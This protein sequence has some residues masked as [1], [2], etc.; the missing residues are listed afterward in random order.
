MEEKQK[1]DLLFETKS[2]EQKKKKHGKLLRTVIILILAAAAL[3]WG[4]ARLTRRVEKYVQES[5]D[6]VKTATVEYGAVNATVTGSGPIEDV[7]PEDISVPA[8]V[9]ILDVL[10]E[11]GDKVEK[12]DIL[13]T[14][15]MPSV[16]SALS[17]IQARIKEKDRELSAVSN[18]KEDAYI[19]AGVKGRVKVLYADAG[20]DVAACMTE[21][22]ALAVISQ[23]G[24][25]SIELTNTSLKAGD[26]VK[27]Q[28]ADGSV[29]DGKAE[30][31]RN[32]R[33]V[34]LVS[35]KELMPGD[36]VTVLS[37]DGETIGSGELDIHNP[38]RV[39]GYTGTVKTVNVKI[40]QSITAASRIFNLK[41]TETTA[42]YDRLLSERKIL[43][44]TLISL[45][46]L[47]ED[48]AL[49][50]PFDGTVLTVKY[51]DDKES[52]EQRA[53]A[54]KDK[55]TEILTLS[56]DE[57]M[58]VEFAVNEMDILALELGQKA[59]IVIESIGK[60]KYEAKI[61]EIN[62]YAADAQGDSSSFSAKAIL[63]KAP[64][65]LSGM[66]ADVTIKVDGSDHVLRIPT[67]A[68]QKT[69]VSA[70]VYTARD[71]QSGKLSCPVTVTLG[72]SNSEYTEIKAGL[73]EG[74]TV[75]YQLEQDQLSFITVVEEAPAE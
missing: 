75:Y 49:S 42:K 64:L 32:G 69:S 1:D 46:R 18:D 50:A 45:L 4:A 34:I 61:T 55:E 8:G 33:A 60:D 3:V 62:K 74:D 7:D 24:W 14:I 70:Y 28:A 12:G 5:G 68:I 73:K 16:S 20:D 21:L 13:A 19:S 10:V 43:E 31:V 6:S 67:E 37:K 65:M 30:S 27:V 29:Q 11:S 63:D 15:S 53:A 58:S 44:K 71:P 23:D 26:K 59:E 25:M 40:N 57:E 48:G 38:I 35:D 39:V 41:D 47:R 36:S 72:L 22:G 17:D 9:E 56:R 52:R 51:S 66:T 2:R 54:S